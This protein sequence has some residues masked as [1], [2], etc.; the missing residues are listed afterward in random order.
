[1]GKNAMQIQ[2][3][4]LNVILNK[5]TIL[6]IML[7]QSINLNVIPNKSTILNVILNK[8]IILNVIF[9]K[10]TKIKCE[11]LQQYQT[12]GNAGQE[13]HPKCMLDTN[14]ILI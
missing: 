6:N 7:D 3:I 1:M 13:Y 4:T 2:S 14:T 10:S 9:D 8:S 11:T 5:S 12:K